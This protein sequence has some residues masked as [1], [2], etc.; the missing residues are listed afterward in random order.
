MRPALS[1]V[2]VALALAGCATTPANPH[3][4]GPPRPYVECRGAPNASPTVVLE[5]GAFETAADWDLVM[6]DLAPGGKVCAYTRAGLGSSP[7]KAR[8]P[9]LIAIAN[10][11]SAVLAGIDDDRPVILVGHSNGALYAETFA[12]LWP[13]RVAG[14]VYVD[15]VNSAALRSPGVM[16]ALGVE[17]RDAHLAEI[18]GRVGLAGAVAQ[19]VVD[20]IGLKGDAAERKYRAMQSLEHLRASYLEEKQIVP[21]IRASRR[22]PPLSP[23]I[24]IAVLIA[25]EHP[26]DGLAKAWRKVQVDSAAQARQRW[27][28]DMPGATH[29]SPLGRDRAYITAAVGWLRGLTVNGQPGPG[30]APSAPPTSPAPDPG[31]ATGR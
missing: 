13:E 3:M 6:D 28:L 1:A 12:R 17:R 22:L 31:R 14:L 18:A 16:A 8:E 26:T 2:A 21:G 9:T 24:S 10:D 19:T 15:G 11:L 29:V 30:P 23:A 7:G 20:R 25:A 27:I 4:V 5:A